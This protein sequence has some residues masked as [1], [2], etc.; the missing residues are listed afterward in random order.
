MNEIP[1]VD[2][3][4]K[5][6]ITFHSIGEEKISDTYYN[7]KCRL[8]MTYRPEDKNA[9]YACADLMPC[10]GLLMRVRRRKKKNGHTEGGEYEYKQDVVGVTKEQYK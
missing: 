9:H 6:D 8:K 3:G 1:G 7:T 10:T 4:K 5:S 2:F